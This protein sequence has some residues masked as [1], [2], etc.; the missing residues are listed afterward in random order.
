MNMNKME[1]NQVIKKM[2]E[3]NKKMNKLMKNKKMKKMLIIKM[4]NNFLRLK[5]IKNKKMN[6]A[7]YKRKFQK[8]RQKIQCVRRNFNCLKNDSINNKNYKKF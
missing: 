1:N 7:Y 2:K 6:N 3:L 5:K 4:K 8:S